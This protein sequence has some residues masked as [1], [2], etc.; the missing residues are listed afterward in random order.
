MIYKWE[1][2]IPTGTPETDPEEWGLEITSGIIV[3]WWVFF[4]WGCA[5]VAH[6]QVLRGPDQ[7]LPYTRGEWLGGNDVLHEFGDHYEVKDEPLHL[8]IRG[9]NYGGTYD[10]K[11]WVVVQ[12][13][14][15]AMPPWIGELLRRLGIG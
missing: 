10:H 8:T 12:V 13:D 3:R 15:P 5:N 14:R 2:T 4:P 11:P 7:L 1:E 9:Y 6:I